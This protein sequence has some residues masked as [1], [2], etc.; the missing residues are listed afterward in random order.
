MK[1]ALRILATVLGMFVPIGVGV[2]FIP[3]PLGEH[4]E[5]EAKASGYVQYTPAE[6]YA[7]AKRICTQCHSD[8][9]IKKYCARCGPPFIVVVPHMQTF[10]RNYRVTTPGLKVEAITQYQAATI[11]QVW[12]AIVGN[13]EGDFREQDV[14]KMLGSYDVLTALY[15]TPVVF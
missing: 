15:R 1:K 8:E 2:I 13:W 10:I 4:F 14:L 9:R 5:N 11:V 12:N 6:A 3:N 7:L